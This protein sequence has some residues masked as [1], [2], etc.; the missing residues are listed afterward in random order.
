MWKNVSFSSN[1]LLGPRIASKG[2][3]VQGNDPPPCQPTDF[4]LTCFVETAIGE[5]Q[6]RETVIPQFG[7]NWSPEKGYSQQIIM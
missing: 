2:T 1:L 3:D 4:H 7:T 6:F 5:S